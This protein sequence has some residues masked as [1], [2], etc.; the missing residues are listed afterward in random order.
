[1]KWIMEGNRGLMY[2]RI[3]RSPSAVLYSADFKFEFGKAWTLKEGGKDRATILSSGRGVH[4][5]LAAAM[6]LE[7]KGIPVGVV[8]MPSIDREMLRKL[9]SSGKLLVVAEQNNG[10][11]WSALGKL[12]IRGKC[13]VRT[14]ALLP[15]NTL[16]EDGAP[17]YIHSATYE[18]L[19]A[20]FGLSAEQIASAISDRL[21]QPA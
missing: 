3:M 1:M 15:I 16:G 18:Q 7:K 8:D 9:C 17:R 2:V 20:Q 6:L 4:E 21:Q 14:D 13:A 5:A 19:L 11:I 10:F 12:A